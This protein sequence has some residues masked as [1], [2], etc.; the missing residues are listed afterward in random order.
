MQLALILLP[1]ALELGRDVWNEM[2]AVKRGMFPT[3]DEL[4][5]VNDEV[6]AK[7]DSQKLS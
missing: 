4:L 1:F 7:I 6:Q 2:E 3:Y 5:A